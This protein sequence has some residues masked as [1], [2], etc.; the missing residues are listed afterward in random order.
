MTTSRR[1]TSAQQTRVKNLITGNETNLVNIEEK[2]EEK[3]SDD[4]SFSLIKKIE[5]IEQKKIIQNLELKNKELVEESKKNFQEKK[6]L[7]EMLEKVSKENTGLYEKIEKIKKIKF[8]SETLYSP[9][10]STKF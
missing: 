1:G 6:N 4:N 10:L 7:K 3:F 2:Y 8:E 9:R 5:R